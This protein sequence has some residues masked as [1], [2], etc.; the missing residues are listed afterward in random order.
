M[1][2]DVNYDMKI[3]KSIILSPDFKYYDFSKRSL[4]YSFFNENLNIYYSSFDFNN[5][6]VLTVASLGDYTLN[7][8]AYG[9]TELTVLL[10]KFYFYLKKSLYAIW[11]M[12]LL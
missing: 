1:E 5:K 6:K 4:L 9:A 10:T 2:C 3:V 12:K 11:M 8:S 7:F